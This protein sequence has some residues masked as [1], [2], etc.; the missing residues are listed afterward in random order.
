MD[1]PTLTR[2]CPGPLIWFEVDTVPTS[3]IL[4]CAACGYFVT[5]GNYH[6]DAHAHTPL[7]RE[8]MA[9]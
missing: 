2:M 8:G 4:E 6:D 7:M 9:G 5:T 1:R 3:A